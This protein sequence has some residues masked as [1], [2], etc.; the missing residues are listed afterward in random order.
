MH[1]TTPAVMARLL[2]LNELQ[3]DRAADDDSNWPST[4][5]ESVTAGY[6]E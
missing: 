4:I 3:A 2:E 5:V 1:G 6:A